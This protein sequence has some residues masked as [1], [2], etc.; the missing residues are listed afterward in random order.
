MEGSKI[1]GVAKGTPCHRAGM[2]EG[3]TY[4]QRQKLL[5]AVCPSRIMLLHFASAG[6]PGVL[7]VIALA[8]SREADIRT[9]RDYSRRSVRLEECCFMYFEPA[10]LPRA[11][12]VIALAC[13]REA[14]ILGFTLGDQSA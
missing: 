8:C 2:L 11:L 7:H 13:S 14:N 6:W 5:W 1:S 12:R 3:G 10:G 4:S 9:D